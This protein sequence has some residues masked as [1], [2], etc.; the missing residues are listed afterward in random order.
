M[1]TYLAPVAET[2]YNTQVEIR[3]TNKIKKKKLHSLINQMID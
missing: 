1:T 2:V 3:N